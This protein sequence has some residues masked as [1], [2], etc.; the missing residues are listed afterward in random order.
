MNPPR[1]ARADVKV[2][3]EKLFRFWSVYQTNVL[4]GLKDVE[5]VHESY[6]YFLNVDSTSFSWLENLSHSVKSFKNYIFLA[7]LFL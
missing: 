2:F 4:F 5:L 7:E 6:R 1:R 3:S